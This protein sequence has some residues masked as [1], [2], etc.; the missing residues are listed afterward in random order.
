MVYIDWHYN[1][2]NMLALVEYRT[3]KPT[4]FKVDYIVYGCLPLN[5]IVFYY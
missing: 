5:D 1:F 4:H 3:S 2:E